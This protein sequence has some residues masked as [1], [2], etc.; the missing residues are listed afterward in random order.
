MEPKQSLL[1]TMD[2]LREQD[3]M[4]L[5]SVEEL[6]TRLEMVVAA[7]EAPNKFL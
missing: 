5:F 2:T 7:G 4:D 3:R 1:K 6:E